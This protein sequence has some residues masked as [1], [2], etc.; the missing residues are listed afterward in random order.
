[1][2][3]YT[4]V[5]VFSI[6]QTIPSSSCI[7]D[8][9]HYLLITIEDDGRMKKKLH[10]LLSLLSISKYFHLYIVNERKRLDVHEQFN[11][12]FTLIKEIFFSFFF[13]ITINFIHFSH[14]RMINLQ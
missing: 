2:H 14:N 3:T 5:M 12:D 1:M 10:K 4:N 8:F 6:M 11:N 7:R 9:T 13:T